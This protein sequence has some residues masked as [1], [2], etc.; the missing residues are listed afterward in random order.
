M[1]ESDLLE[2]AVFLMEVLSALV[3]VAGG[4]LTVSHALEREGGAA[5]AV[6]RRSAFG[7]EIDYRRVLAFAR[8]AVRR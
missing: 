2:T 1:L 7:F 6:S 3:I 5:P 8:L 4:A